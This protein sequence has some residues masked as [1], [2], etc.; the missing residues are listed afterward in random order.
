MTL[1]SVD[2]SVAIRKFARVLSAFLNEL[3]NQSNTSNIMILVS[4]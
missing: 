4:L 1:G 2:A 3:P